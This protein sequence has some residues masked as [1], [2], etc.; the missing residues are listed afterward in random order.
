MPE[1]KNQFTG[2][3]MNKDLDER[4]VP[5][6]EYRD[7]MNIQ[8][9][10]S[11][12][13][14]VG[15]VQNILGNTPGC[16]YDN[17]NV[18]P[19]SAGS[20]VIGSISDEKN[21]SLYWMVAGPTIENVD[22]LPLAVNE[23]VSLK[24]MI[25]RTNSNTITGCEPV[26][27]DKHKFCTGI[28][29][30]TSTNITN[31]ILLDDDDLYDSVTP[32][33]YATG[34][35]GTSEAFGPTLVKNVGYVNK[36]SAHYN[37][38]AEPPLNL[39]SS[40]PAP[41][42][43]IRTFEKPGPYS[44]GNK[45]Y[46]QGL[47]Y[48][49]IHSGTSGQYP[50]PTNLPT[51]YGN[52]QLLWDTSQGA[53]PPQFV[54]GSTVNV[55]RNT[56]NPDIFGTSTIASISLANLQVSY[57]A[58]YETLYRDYIIIEIIPDIMPST[59]ALGQ[60]SSPHPLKPS[61]V[62]AY[63][64]L[65]VNANAV[66]GTGAIIPSNRITIEHSSYSVLSSSSWLNEI[67]ETFYD[68]NGSLIPGVEM[69]I[70]HSIGAGN[71]FPMNS[72]IDPTSVDPPDLTDPANPVY[73]NEF[74]IICCDFPHHNPNDP[75]NCTPGQPNRALQF[76]PPK[77]GKPITFRTNNLGGIKAVFLNSA[78]DLNSV[79]SICFESERVL[80][81]NQNNLVT[82]INIVDDMLFWT[83]NETEPKKINITR[84]IAGTDFNGDTHTAIENSNTGLSLL[85][86]YAPI[87]EE[88]ITVIRKNPKNALNL[89]L[90]SG[91]DPNLNYNGVVTTVVE[92]G[93]NASPII[94]SSNTS[95]THDFSTLTI[96]DKIKLRIESNRTVAWEPGG[97]LLLK[98]Y[99]DGVSPVL[100][101]VN[102]SIRGLITDWV[103]NN[104]RVAVG[105]IQVEIQIVGIKG[106]PPSPD[107]SSNNNVLKYAVGLENKEE[108]IFENKLP[109][110]SYRY[111]Y[112]DGEYSTFAPFSEVA[113]L[114]TTLSY[115][116]SGGFNKGMTN[117]IRSV[118]VKGFKTTYNN[119][120]N[121]DDITEIDILYKED[122]SP[123][124]YIVETIGA[125]DIPPADG[126]LIPWYANEYE[127]KSETIKNLLPSN[128]LL[129]LWDNV[130]KKALAQEIT[131]SRIV[132]ANYEQNYDLKVNGQ[133]YKPNF[134]N[135]LD[136]WTPVSSGTPEKS[137]KSLR[138]YKLGVVF[139]D[140]Y[141]RETPVIISESGGF[142]V[143]KIN[144]D[145]ANKLAVGLQG[146]APQEM[147]YFKFYIKET[148]NEYYNL[149]MD[150]WYDAQDGNIWLAFPSVDRNKLDLESSLYFK[151]GNR[152]DIIENDTRYKVLAI[153]N[154]APDYIKT[155]KIR[156][157][158]TKHNPS[159]VIDDQDGRLFGEQNDQLLNAPTINQ[160]SFR[161][162]YAAGRF[163]N[164]SLSNL[165]EL[166][167]NIYIQFV[168][169]TKFSDQYKISSITAD[170]LDDG[171]GL[172]K[173]PTSYFVT[174]DTNLKDDISFIFNDA[175][176][177]SFIEDDIHVQFTKEVVENKPKF[178][179]RF[180]VKIENDGQI[181]TQLD[182][183]SIGTNYIEKASKKVYVL[184]DD[185]TLRAKSAHT[186]V[187]T[188]G[189]SASM[190]SYNNST[191]N[192]DYPSSTE[193]L[194]SNPF[195][196]NWNYFIARQ[197][198]FGAFLGTS[199]LVTGIQSS[200]FG[201]QYALGDP[202]VWFIDRSTKKYTV[203]SNDAGVNDNHL[204]WAD[205][206]NMN[207]FQPQCNLI[208]DGGDCGPGDPPHSPTWRI[209]G[210]IINNAEDSFVNLSFGGIGKIVDPNSFK[211][212]GLDQ[213]LTW[214]LD[215]PGEQM[216]NF[217]SIGQGIDKS[218]SKYG[219]A[220]T[221]SFQKRLVAGFQFKWEE[222]PTET[223]YTIIDQT[224]REHNVR[225]S[226]R[227]HGGGPGGQSARQL[228]AAPSSYHKN[229][230][231]SVTPS[232]SGWDPASPVGTVS[233]IN[234]GA[235]MS[236]GLI[237]G[238]GEKS[239]LTTNLF[240][241]KDVDAGGANNTVGLGAS[242]LQF[243]QNIDEVEIGMQMI[244]TNSTSSL[245]LTTTVTSVDYSNKTVTFEPVTVSAI[246]DDD[247]IEFAY[248]IRLKE[249]YIY[250]LRNSTEPGVNYI[251]VD[252]IS[253]RCTNGNTSKPK[254]SL[255]KGMML[256]AFNID[257]SI[258]QPGTLGRPNNFIIKSIGE[259]DQTL[260]NGNGG[261]KIELSGYH[262]PLHSGAGGSGPFDFVEFT[263]PSNTLFKINERLRFKQVSM[264]GAS[265][266]TEHNTHTYVLG[267][268][269]PDG[270]GGT[271]SGGIA[272]VGYTMQM[273]EPVDEYGDGGNLPPDPF[274]WETEPKET[275]ELDIYYEISESNPVTL[276][277]KTIKTAIPIGSSITN[278]SG[279]GFPPQYS[280]AIIANNESENGD[281]IIIDTG[282]GGVF[283]LWVGNNLSNPQ[284]SADGTLPIRVGDKLQVTRPSGVTFDVEIA[285]ILPFSGTQVISGTTN[286]FR[287]S[288]SVYNA[289]YYLNWHNCYSFGN[290]VESNRIKDT[291]NSPFMAN[292]VKVSTTLR[293][294]Y[295]AER[296]KHGLIYSG[297]Y[298]SNSGV[299]NLNQFIQAENIT[300][301]VNPIYGSIQKLHS[302]WGQSGD[303]VALC[304]DR[305]LKILANKDA[306]FNADGNINV[307]AT[308]KVLGTATPYSG[309]FGI[310]K[311]PESFASEAYRAY[312][313]DKVRGAV[314]RLSVDGLTPISNHGMK[315]WFKE[316]LKLTERLI[317]SYDDKKDEYNITLFDINK[318]VSFKEDVRGWVSFKSF[319][320]EIGISCADN[321]YTFNNATLYKHHDKNV[322][323]NTFYNVHE[324]SSL[325]V[326]LNESPGVVKN[327][328]TINYEG[329]QG[330]MSQVTNYNVFDKT[331]W[332][333]T[334][335]IHGEPVYSTISNNI[336]AK[337]NQGY[338]LQSL[339][340][341]V[342]WQV[343]KIETDKEEGSIKEFIE[344]EGKWFN[345]I[346][347]K[348]WL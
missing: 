18:N 85:S 221:T 1:I 46:M 10:T 155:R 47:T 195:G 331:S 217:F 305:V 182:D 320:P 31:A 261:F 92:G 274:V 308:N 160:I 257:S 210:G 57:K 267:G 103:D 116:A 7:A 254:Y 112:A 106:T 180:F 77:Q 139:T 233:G 322:D 165:D 306:L 225:F 329:S 52:I 255:H 302:G 6:G 340:S 62:E 281:E 104:F 202:G 129:R 242:T 65:T 76:P 334:F 285:E 141:G 204:T 336:T 319:V 20:K 295:K 198:Y 245:D 293:E 338:N 89:E 122:A 11:D 105:T 191:W 138:D 26:F 313:T 347:G 49:F 297:I 66:A 259:F 61:Q 227:D 268:A 177:P 93:P 301:D 321:Y 290:G 28:T 272:A 207:N 149:A 9:S 229:W 143:S 317:G 346:K 262:T 14:D 125:L 273:V 199:N 151:K 289:M 97:F 256:D 335:D 30:S 86:N 218:G 170:R 280:S 95:A 247:D 74:N 132:Y 276:N 187:T 212:V 56:N 108:K 173:L 126:A 114:P 188:A 296:R 298:N 67:Y 152:Y 186:L 36:F 185:D 192:D 328:Y 266:W 224:N 219:D 101:L 209:G 72:C 64:D 39:G 208:G 172:A 115:D 253:T 278:R 171:T 142:K 133:K 119:G 43:R 201:L 3:K 158:K 184:D 344:K 83:D 291:F 40:E 156:I 69:R 27:V 111:K 196:R 312:F 24:D 117:N 258:E 145:K 292:G 120:I 146:D 223:I 87:R 163:I 239:E 215:L 194:N 60:G 228:Q 299:N 341:K 234:G 244:N 327:F 124:V 197:S 265:N 205:S 286:H 343:E 102:W 128:Q 140:E 279:E 32:G 311:N 174:L 50:E 63:P 99:T 326:I 136:T 183:S 220:N 269:N 161:M 80:N 249:E 236:N 38:F 237:L 113:F 118:K 260:D 12:E 109:R 78:H 137:I 79:E 96:G 37:V 241:A 222:D 134:K 82:G 303:L 23:T 75:T 81:F 44:V 58:G 287:L 250:G 130:P 91:R 179:G 88:H 70:D 94:G 73:D 144:S 211:R 316:H 325:T 282:A 232:M 251:V 330:F 333:G 121:E 332:N 318:T 181:K 167:E 283:G 345:Y 248:T 270:L 166:K 309:E 100:P 8:V 15:A 348:E 213:T 48:T 98:E 33:M 324:S 314:M 315:N 277:P 235:G 284:P 41:G 252:N 16:T 90:L 135:Y 13:S 71:N 271:K 45:K 21:D 55:R 203:P 127:I 68:E 22:F 206:V 59:S 147:A 226:R 275:A 153:E 29:P 148:S 214:K 300:K 189:V 5:K 169:S 337:D 240:I 216:T 339:S 42:F 19:V 51:T 84:S 304:E 157:G 53:L 294:E 246:T 263:N 238:T 230:G 162:N 200:K 178:D 131:G 123:N 168:S 17:T 159:Q 231:F 307:T 342:G 243:K 4:L 264:N 154:E 107:I 34:F 35:N 2:G 150:R 288:T 176:N 164:S 193:V 323:R 54:V 110:F 25:M 175:S 310:S 190:T